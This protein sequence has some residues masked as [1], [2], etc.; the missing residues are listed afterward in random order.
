M[1]RRNFFKTATLGL[2]TVALL[3]FT[4]NTLSANT[5]LI[6]ASESP[7]IPTSHAIE[8]INNNIKRRDIFIGK[9]V[10]LQLNDA[11]LD[12][13]RIAEKYTKSNSYI[14]YP[15]RQTG[16]T[17]AAA[18]YL[19]YRLIHDRNSSFLTVCINLD[20]CSYFMDT[21][22]DMYN[23]LPNQLSQVKTYSC[24]KL[25]MYINSNKL[26]ISSYNNIYLNLCATHYKLAFA[27][28]YSYSD[29]N[30]TEVCNYNVDRVIG[31]SYYEP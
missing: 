16:Y 10:P 30:M 24:N 11:Q 18:A 7:L 28:E 27:Q 1:N 3:P 21:I 12:F 14:S 19:L 5:S 31:Y 8:W 20:Q 23:H 9:N 13:I 15:K 22:R 25:S 2:G 4:D 26:V 29:V 6:S 17:T